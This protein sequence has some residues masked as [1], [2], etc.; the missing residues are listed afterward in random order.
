V[1]LLHGLAGMKCRRYSQFGSLE[2]SIQ[3]WRKEIEY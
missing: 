2:N 1:G 3:E